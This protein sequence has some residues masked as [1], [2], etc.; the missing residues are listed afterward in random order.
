MDYTCGAGRAFR[1]GMECAHWARIA[2]NRAAHP[3][4]ACMLGPC[5]GI[6]HAVHVCCCTQAHLRCTRRARTAGASTQCARPQTAACAAQRRHSMRAR[7][8][9]EPQHTRCTSAAQ[10]SVG[11]S[12]M[13]VPSTCWPPPPMHAHMLAASIHACTHAW[14]SACS[15]GASALQPSK[16]HPCY[17]VLAWPSG[18]GPGPGPGQGQA[19]VHAVQ[20][21]EAPT[22]HSGTCS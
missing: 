2:I 12:H 10:R 19:H 4:Y 22:L 15:L 13:L 6:R 18:P 9:P 11:G 7:S 5:A 3:C 17:A 14:K 1:G 21:A 20:R 16:P 8:T